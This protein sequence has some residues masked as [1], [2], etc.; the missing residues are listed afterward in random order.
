MT[1][2]LFDEDILA[3]RTIRNYAAAATTM[4]VDALHWA[5]HEAKQTGQPVRHTANL[6]R[7]SPSKIYRHQRESPVRQKNRHHEKVL[8]YRCRQLPTYQGD[9]QTRKQISHQIRGQDE[10][11]TPVSF[12]AWAK[13]FQD[14]RAVAAAATSWEESLLRMSIYDGIHE[15][16]L[17]LR[18]VARVLG[19]P[20]ATAARRRLGSTFAPPVWATPDTYREA[21]QITWSYAPHRKE[22]RV[23][24]EWTD[25]PDGSRSVGLLS[26]GVAALSDKDR[27]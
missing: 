21:E 11:P 7:V 15:Q 12:E 14:V 17:S 27:P 24:Y 26:A 5:A 9:E 1:E 10:T 25:H 2:A 8:Y 18:Q 20:H 16:G 19:V 4:E 22:G 6:L 13:Y 3:Y 23:P